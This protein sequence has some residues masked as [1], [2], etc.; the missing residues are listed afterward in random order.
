MLEVSPVLKS[1]SLVIFIRGEKTRSTVKT[2]R[3][4][5]N[6][7]RNQDCNDEPNSCARKR[8]LLVSFDFESIARN[9]YGVSQFESRKLP[10]VSFSS[11]ATYFC[12][13]VAHNQTYFVIWSSVHR[14]RE[15]R[16]SRNLS[17]CRLVN[18]KT[19]LVLDSLYLCAND[20]FPCVILRVVCN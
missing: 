11:Y 1:K 3:C 14:N 7:Q 19:M 6:C 12:K 20:I 5:W 15:R 4:P 8:W 9:E 16:G 2:F 10:S 13:W 17:T 18:I